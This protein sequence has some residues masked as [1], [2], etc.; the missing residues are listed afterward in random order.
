MLVKYEQ[1]YGSFFCRQIC[2]PGSDDLQWNLEWRRS[3]GQWLFWSLRFHE[4][5]CAC[6][7]AYFRTEGFMKFGFVTVVHN[8]QPLGNLVIGWPSFGCMNAWWYNW[9]L[10]TN[11]RQ[12]ST[13]L[14]T[15]IWIHT[16]DMKSAARLLDGCNELKLC[17]V[18]YCLLFWWSVG[19]DVLNVWAC[20]MHTR[21]VASDHLSWRQE[22]KKPTASVGA[23]NSKNQQQL[24]S[25]CYSARLQ[26]AAGLLVCCR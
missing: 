3:T 14:G 17:I 22:L 26:S 18:M 1:M 23:K 16:W 6:I 21:L 25:S 12:V 5:G 2:E 10:L 4:V 19:M 15:N 9:W 11:L 20:Y 24:H 7:L 8:A 13:S